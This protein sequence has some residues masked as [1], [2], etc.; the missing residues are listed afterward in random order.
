M[1]PPPPAGPPCSSPPAAVAHQP[2]R[3]G[4]GAGTCGA[5]GEATGEWRWYRMSH[6]ASCL[7]PGRRPGR[8]AGGGH[9][10]AAPDQRGHA[11]ARG[12]AALRT[13]LPS[14]RCRLHAGEAGALVWARLSRRGW[15]HACCWLR[16]ALLAGF[17]ARLACCG[18][19]QGRPRPRRPTETNSHSLAAGAPAGGHSCGGVCQDGGRVAALKGKLGG[20]LPLQWPTGSSAANALGRAFPAVRCCEQ[21][22][23]RRRCIGRE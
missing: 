19:D 3:I 2:A 11:G 13:R 16:R 14:D 12:G 10:G 5:A 4:A 21:P 15:Q 7:L 9:W 8:Q 1:P 20:Q 6:H 17:G 22:T 18:W 23:A